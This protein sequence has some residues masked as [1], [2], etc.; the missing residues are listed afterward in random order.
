MFW[1]Y[2]HISSS[3]SVC[4]TSS[5]LLLYLLD[6]E[7]LLTLTPTRYFATALSAACLYLF[8][9]L[10]SQVGLA[11]QFVPDSPTLFLNLTSWYS[12]ARTFRFKHDISRFNGFLNYSQHMRC[13]LSLS[14]SFLTRN[15]GLLFMT[16][17]KVSTLKLVWKYSTSTVRSVLSSLSLTVRYVSW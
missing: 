9:F 3:A 16:R 14:L 4:L 11:R 1:K 12:L 15:D 8:L 6:E 13:S 2:F 5:D 10:S 17:V 7:T